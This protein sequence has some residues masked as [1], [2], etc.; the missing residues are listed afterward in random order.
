MRK[1]KGCKKGGEVRF[2]RKEADR[3]DGRWQTGEVEEG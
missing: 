2:E 1:S 3:K